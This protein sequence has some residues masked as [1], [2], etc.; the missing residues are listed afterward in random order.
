MAHISKSAL[1]PYAARD[2]YELVNDI[3]AYPFFLPWCRSAKILSSSKDEVCASIELSRGGFR[4]SFTTKNRL[5]RHKMI[6][7]RLVEGPFRHLHGYWRFAPLRED[8]CKV[9]LD[10]SFEI[11]GKLLSVAFG[12]VFHQ[13]AS[14][15]VD[16]FCKRAKEVYG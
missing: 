5:Q 9:S 2:M 14:T 7:V 15:L 10:L 11:S 12:P 3:E 4:K 16:A 13:I 6:E 8:A 1:V